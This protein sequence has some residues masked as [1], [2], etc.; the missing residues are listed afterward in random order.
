MNVSTASDNNEKK[1]YTPLYKTFQNLL[2]RCTFTI[3]PFIFGSLINLIFD[4]ENIYY[5][6]GEFLLYSVSLISSSILAYQ[7]LSSF[8]DLKKGWLNIFALLFLVFTSGIYAVIFSIDK[9]PKLDVMFSISIITF[10]IA[11]LIYFFSQLGFN[12]KL[13][14]EQKKLEQYEFE[15]NNSDAN[16]VRQQNQD[17]LIDGLN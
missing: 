5:A 16:H 9:D 8:S 7:S 14:N 6:R 10:L 1:D 17:D 12:T 11:I 2:F 13:F 4:Y 3:L 15:K